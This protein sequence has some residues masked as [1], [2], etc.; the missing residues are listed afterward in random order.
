M[1]ARIE[2]ISGGYGIKLT[3]SAL[4][5]QIDSLNS[6]GTKTVELY[7]PKLKSLAAFCNVKNS[8]S[9]NTTVEELT[10][11]TDTQVSSIVSFLE[12]GFNFYDR[13]L[14]KLTLHVDTSKATIASLAF[15]HQR[16]LEEITGTPLDL[17]SV[18]GTG[19]GG[20]FN[21]CQAL[22]EV[23][24]KGAV[25]V[26]LQ[27]KESKKLS[28][29]S[30]LSIFDCLADDVSDKALSL[31]LDA[32]NTAFETSSGAADGSASAEWTALVE[33]KPNW[34]ISLV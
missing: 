14:K 16:T 11:R 33:S 12:C 7:L 34:T 9:V 26:N 5:L 17:S 3:D 1:P 6:L 30:I 32:V 8:E 23:R 27:L 31:S 24:F 20:M 19:C 13:A 28:K 29:A 22:K 10:I 21:Y 25:K 2:A 18:S 4:N 15:A